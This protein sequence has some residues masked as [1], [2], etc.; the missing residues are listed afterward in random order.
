MKGVRTLNLRRVDLQADLDALRRLVADIEEHDLHPALGERKHFYLVEL[1]FDSGAEFPGLVVEGDRGLVSYL[2]FIEE[3]RGSWT[4]ETAVHPDYRT[5]SVLNDVLKA[6]QRHVKN[7]GG[8]VIR[9]W[10]Y[11]PEVVEAAERAS[12]GK[13]RELHHMRAPLPIA[14]SPRFPSGISVR[15]FR[16]GIDEEAWLEGNNRVFAGHPENGNWALQDLDRRRRRPWFSSEGLRMAW[17]GKA[18]AG[19]CWTKVPSPRA[20]EIYVIGVVPGYQRMGLGKAL[21]LEGVR[22]MHT[23]HHAQACVLYVDAGNTAAVNMY[24]SMGFRHHHSDHS[25]LLTLD[26]GSCSTGAGTLPVEL[27]CKS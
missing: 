14:E 8:S 22:H 24:R 11:I 13:E 12:F 16:E 27:R 5:E 4:V 18:L 6:V 17:D 25:Y 7:R 20:G 26:K 2:A 1:P 21:L 3:D 10:A 9:L 23:Y 19:F 15:G